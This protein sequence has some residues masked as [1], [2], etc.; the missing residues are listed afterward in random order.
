MKPIAITVV[1]YT[2]CLYLWGASNESHA[3]D[4]ALAV[5]LSQT[6]SATNSR[7]V[8]KTEPLRGE[9]TEVKI[10]GQKV[11]TMEG[12]QVYSGIF[13]PGLV[14]ITT[15]GGEAKIN[16]EANKEYV[17][18][19]SF[20]GSASGFALFGLAG[21]GLNATYP[22]T[23][24]A[25]SNIEDLHDKTVT[26]QPARSRQKSE[27]DR[28]PT[29]QVKTDVSQ[30]RSAAYKRLKE[31]DALRKEGVLTQQEF[32]LKKAEILKEM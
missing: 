11:A 20:V 12:N 1:A 17:F 29:E 18:E 24:K 7:I 3:A 10:N 6:A 15:K 32:D 27:Q 8:I 5:P 21:S 28:Q 30:S 19:I 9:S 14:L 25:T 4:A 13:S 2:L 31:L 22:V 26:E 16:A 23:L